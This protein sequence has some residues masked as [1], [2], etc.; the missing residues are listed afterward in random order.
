MHRG[1]GVIR[2]HSPSIHN[3]HVHAHKKPHARACFC[4]GARNVGMETVT[5]LA[6]APEDN[7]ECMPT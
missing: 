6:A 5:L 1:G 2:L 4:M 3:S 7:I